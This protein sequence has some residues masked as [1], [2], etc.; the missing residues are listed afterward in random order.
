MNTSFTARHFNA[1]TRLQDYSLEA[2]KKLAK[3]YD[4]IIDCDVV[5]LPNESH[6][7]P[8]QAELTIK[9]ART[10][11]KASESAATYEQALGKAIDNMTR[12]LVR[13]KE[14]RFAKG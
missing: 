11:L 4:G 8:Q 5:L 7:E 14:K 2:V 13:Y 10:T 1:S 12:Q 9:V 6:D 3:F